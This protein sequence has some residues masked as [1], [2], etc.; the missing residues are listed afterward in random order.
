MSS[1]TSSRMYLM[2]V[3]AFLIC[4]GGNT[5]ADFTF[6][7]PVNLGPTVN[8]SSVDAVPSPSADGLSLYFNSN[9][10]GG[11][12]NH[13]LWVT[14]RATVSDPWNPAV[15]LGP[16]VNS[17]SNDGTP[18]ISANGLEL[19]FSSSRS[20]GLGNNDLWL[21]RR[22][23]VF[24][25]WGTPVNLGSMVN[26]SSID[27]SPS[28]S[29]DGLE[30]FLHSNRPSEYR[31]DELWVAR[32]ETTSDD[33]GNP[34]NLGPIVNSR[35]LD[36]TPSISSDGL[37][38][39]FQSNRSGGYGG[40]VDIWLTSRPTA[41]DPWEA[42]VNLG[43]AVNSSGWEGNPGISAGGSTFYFVSNRGGGV[44]ALDIW[45]VPLEPVVDLNGDYRIDIQDLLILIDHW[46]L[47]EPA[48]DMG[49]MPWG[50]GVIDAADLEVL[51]SCWG[52]ELDD[53]YFIGHWK[54]DESEG[55][56]AEESVGDNDGIVIGGPMW[57]PEDGHV[58][59][60]LTLDGID[61]MI[62]L[63]PVLNPEEGPF[64]VFAWVKGG[65]PGQVIVSQRPGENWLMVDVDGKLMTD[66]K[67]DGRSPTSLYSEAVITDGNWHRIGFVWDGAQR[68]LYVDGAHV[69]IDV[70]ARLTRSTGGLAIGVGK[71]NQPGTFWSG[72]IDDVRIYDRAVTP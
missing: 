22:E 34:V 71:G 24:D 57:Q 11:Y 18:S 8:S 72:M 51:M 43:S 5:K 21:A 17:S 41:D 56:L 69:A 40:V 3:L 25:P 45:Q 58:N 10:S 65:G 12:G 48:Y 60:A 4:M 55:M 33:W 36:A 67:S 46:G 27:W 68:N 37:L 7:T 52:Q 32:R 35:S 1:G 54:L 28:I 14:T 70:Q 26:S 50:D 29:A 2:V 6:G 47:N 63:K 13:D 53:P 19:Y 42:P 64:S 49:P 66:L 9:R 16:I 20:G 38:L 59:G 23:T 44:G 39:F 31:G 15:N 61:D 62:I 30:L